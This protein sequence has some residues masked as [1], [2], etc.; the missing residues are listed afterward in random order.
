MKRE[1]VV[2]VAAVLLTFIVMD[3]CHDSAV[4]EWE[5]R[6]E[7]VEERARYQ[8]ERAEEAKAQADSLSEAADEA[9]SVAEASE[10]RIRVRID[11]IRAETPDSLREH[12]AIVRRDSIIDA[13]SEVITQ[14]RRSFELERQASA[15]LRVALSNAMERGDS[16]QAVLDD[17][18]SDRPW[19]LPRLGAGVAA[20]LDQ[21][22]RPNTVAGVTLSWEIDF[23]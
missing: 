9:L 10:E 2:A 15:S 4:S 17:R 1:I 19:W 21:Q 8:R 14:V 18:P 6:V 20:G 13:Q 12:P 5:S 3:R 11:T 16:L 23:N 7:R 22:G